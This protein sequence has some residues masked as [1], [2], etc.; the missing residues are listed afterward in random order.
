LKRSS[1][2][3]R[4]QKSVPELGESEPQTQSSLWVTVNHAS[5]FRREILKQKIGSEFTD[6]T[7]NIM[8]G[9]LNADFEPMI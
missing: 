2:I 4:Y 7:E 8:L 1:P 3:N 6:N 5:R 9:V